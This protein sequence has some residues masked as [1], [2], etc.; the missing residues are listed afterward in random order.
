MRGVTPGLDRLDAW[1]HYSN[2]LVSRPAHP[3]DIP[4]VAGPP[5]S[6]LSGQ[7]GRV[8]QRVDFLELADADLGVDGRRFELDMPE[9]RLKE[10]HVGPVFEHESRARVAE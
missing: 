1:P 6:R 2:S 9:H 3:P 5:A 10:P 8:G 7:P 4:L